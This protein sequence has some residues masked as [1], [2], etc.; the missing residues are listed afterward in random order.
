MIGIAGRWRVIPAVE[1]GAGLAFGTGTHDDAVVP[2][3]RVNLGMSL[4][5]IE[6][7][8]GFRAG[9]PWNVFALGGVGVASVSARGA[10]KTEGKGRGMLRFGLGVERRFKSF[11]ID[12]TARAIVIGENADVQ[13]PIEDV[14]GSGYY[15]ARMGV[16]ALSLAIDGSYYF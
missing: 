7:R 12:T 8:Y 10:G 13:E 11:A 1:V 14:P 4:L 6:G 3:A 2:P 5:Y 9:H 15:F 16:F